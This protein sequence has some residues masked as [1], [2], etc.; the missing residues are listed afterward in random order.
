MISLGLYAVT[1]LFW[2]PIVFMQI[3]MRDLARKRRSKTGSCR[4]ATSHFSTAGFC[5]GFRG[6]ARSMIA[7]PF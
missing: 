4:R 5:L 6:L 3:E 2:V 7:K 1:G